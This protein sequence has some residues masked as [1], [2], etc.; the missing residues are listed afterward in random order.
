MSTF[1][2]IHE[3]LYQIYNK[4]RRKYRGNARDTKQMCLMW[5]TDSPPEVIEDTKPF[6]DIEKAFNVSI[7][8]DIALDLYDMTLDQ[9]AKKIVELQKRK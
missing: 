6:Q 7:D 9:A 4:H 5:S 3:T 8:D 2:E 1:K